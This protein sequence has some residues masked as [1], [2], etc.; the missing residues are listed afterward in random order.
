MSLDMLDLLRFMIRFIKNLVTSL[1][2]C[3][4]LNTKYPGSMGYL[5]IFSA[6]RATPARPQ[7]AD[8]GMT[9]S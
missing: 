4:P 3:R 7:V 9:F 8:R 2:L 6:H 1:G 5:P